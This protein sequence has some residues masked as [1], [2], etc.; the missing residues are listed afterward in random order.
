MPSGQTAKWRVPLVGDQ[1]RKGWTWTW[2]QKRREMHVKTVVLDLAK[3]GPSWSMSQEPLQSWVCMLGKTNALDRKCQIWRRSFSALRMSISHH[4]AD[5]QLSWTEA[6]MDSGL[7]RKSTSRKWI[8]NVVTNSWEN[9]VCWKVIL[10]RWRKIVEG[11]RNDPCF[12]EKEGNSQWKERRRGRKGRESGNR[13]LESLSL[14]AREG[15]DL[16]E[17]SAQC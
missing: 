1:E 17:P 2:L 3:D 11:F 10:H 6:L 9:W 12:N 4:D 7:E 5:G 13:N 8:E 14:R 16:R 15:R